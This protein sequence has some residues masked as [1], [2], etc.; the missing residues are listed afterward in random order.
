MALPDLN[1]VKDDSYFYGVDPTLVHNDDGNI[2]D[3]SEDQEEL[4]KDDRPFYAN[5]ME[6]PEV[7]NEYHDWLFGE[8]WYI[9]FS[10]Q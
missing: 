8:N 5:Q 10:N 2:L 1:E 7:Q 9:T 3:T 4:V 6:D